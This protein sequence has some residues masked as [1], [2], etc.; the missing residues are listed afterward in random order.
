MRL[1]LIAAELQSQ[2]RQL[3]RTDL[4]DPSTIREMR[5]VVSVIDMMVR[6]IEATAR[7]L[8]ETAEKGA[9]G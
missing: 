1:S 7:R 9:R 5:A 3:E 4:E 8:G 6:T 2:A